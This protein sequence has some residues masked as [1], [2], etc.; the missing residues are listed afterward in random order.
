[1]FSFDGIFG[2][3]PCAV[4]LFDGRRRCGGRGFILEPS[5]NSDGH[6]LALRS[7]G[8]LAEGLSPHFVLA[9]YSNMRYATT[10]VFKSILDSIRYRGI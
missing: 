6:I 7:A 8:K 10:V 1:M 2:H 4:N 5:D 3:A 9:T